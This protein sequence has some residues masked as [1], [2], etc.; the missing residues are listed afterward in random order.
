MGTPREEVPGFVPRSWPGLQASGSEC[1]V[2]A[3]GL[4]VSTSLWVSGGCVR[5]RGA[6]AEVP[7]WDVSSGA[8]PVLQTLAWPEN[9]GRSLGPFPLL[10]GVF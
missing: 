6:G 8:T 3:V 4:D 9:G 5:G 2:G 1:T 10:A 7:V